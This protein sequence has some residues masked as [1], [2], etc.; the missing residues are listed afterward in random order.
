VFSQR[1]D[2]FIKQEQSTPHHVF[3]ASGEGVK[4]PRKNSPSHSVEDK[5]TQVD[6]TIVPTKDKSRQPIHARSFSMFKNEP[7]SRNHHTRSPHHLGKVCQLW[8][9]VG[10]IREDHVELSQWPL[11]KPNDICAYRVQIIP[12]QGPALG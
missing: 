6:V 4:R 8:P 5:Q 9:I 12:A 2:D 10:R 7:T 11:Q 3:M 1:H